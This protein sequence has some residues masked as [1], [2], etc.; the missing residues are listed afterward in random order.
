ML[1]DAIQFVME[2][3]MSIA[4]GGVAGARTR[5]TAALMVACAAGRVAVVASRL[6]VAA[7]RV[8]LTKSKNVMIGRYILERLWPME[9]VERN[10]VSY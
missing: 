8:V 3:E 10:L 9:K 2:L 1:T 6:E 4:L 7:A 5:G